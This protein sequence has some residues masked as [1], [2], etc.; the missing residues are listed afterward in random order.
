MDENILYISNAGTF[1]T[2][3]WKMTIDLDVLV[4]DAGR[5]CKDYYNGGSFVSI[6]LFRAKKLLQLILEYGTEQDLQKVDRV[7][8]KHE[9]LGPYW[10]K[11]REAKV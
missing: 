10:E 7:I 5:R 2:S 8:V 9:K 11:L 1:R 3:S 6:P 4:K